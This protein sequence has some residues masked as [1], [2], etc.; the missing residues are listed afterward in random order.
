MVS[1]SEG[2]VTEV[3]ETLEQRFAAAFQS[4]IAEART[5]LAQLVELL[6]SKADLDDLVTGSR[7]PSLY[8]ATALGAFFKVAPSALLQAKSPSVGVSFRLGELEGIRDV[9]GA[10]AHATKLL[11]VDR[12]TRDWG[13]EEPVTPLP[14]FAPSKAWNYREA[15]EK[16]ASRLRAF[17]D[18]DD[19]EPVGDLTALVESLGYPVEYRALPKDVH[20]IS[21]PEEW[22]G[23]TAWVV[24][25]NCEDNWARQRFTLAH[26]LSHILQ[27]D[28]GQIVID[29]AT[30][31]ND[32]RAERIADSFARNFLLPEEAIQEAYSKSG[33]VSGFEQMA[34]LVTNLMLTYGVSRDATMY[35]LKET[36]EGVTNNRAFAIC[37][38][39]KIADLMHIS[40]NDQNWVEVKA[41]QGNPFPSDRLTQQALNSY[42]AGLVP[43]RAV[44]DVLT[45]GDESAAEE[46]LRSAGWDLVST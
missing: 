46:Q 19:L 25:I 32:R 28:S 15:G 30:L 31:D 45:D 7:M 18:I 20:G 37:R 24:L 1:T 13:H 38:E 40:G 9:S 4:L 6:G 43:L 12:L 14:K 29:R 39:A 10:V 3:G 21:V 16:T 41:N 22:D 11:A 42:A 27:R 8:E 36:I 44:A 23:T 26:E 17:L 33:E 2:A 5:P 35:A 34:L